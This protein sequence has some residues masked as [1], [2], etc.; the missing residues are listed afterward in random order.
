M[1]SYI[2]GEIKKGDLVGA[3]HQ[4]FVEIGF[5]LGPGKGQSQQYHSIGRLAHWLDKL[6][7]GKIKSN[8]KPYVAYISNSNHYRFIKYSPEL[9][10]G[11]RSLEDYNKALEAL[12][13][14]NI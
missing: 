5:Y 14:L 4:G 13:L 9:I 11:E 8:T 1:N 12:K 3:V 10:I 7:V 2:S 6:N